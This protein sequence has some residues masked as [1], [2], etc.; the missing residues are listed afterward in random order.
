LQ[1]QVL[2]NRPVDNAR[3]FNG[4]IDG[5]RVYN[6]QLTPVEIQSLVEP[7]P[8]AKVIRFHFAL[9]RLHRGLTDRAPTKR[10]WRGRAQ[11]GCPTRRYVA[12]PGFRNRQ[13]L[14]ID[15][16]IAVS[17]LRKHSGFAAW[18]LFE[19]HCGATSG[20]RARPINRGK[21]E[22]CAELSEPSPSAT[23]SRF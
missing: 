16:R 15:R 22:A 5:V 7:A 23:S 18:P 9:A 1:L 2:G 17:I 21:F 8:D 4:S 14:A 12:T 20:S 19:A 11:V 10:Q 6:R 13:A 3:N